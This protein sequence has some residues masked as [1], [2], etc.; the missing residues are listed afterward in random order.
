MFL[1]YFCV[2]KRKLVILFVA[3]LSAVAARAQYDA[4]FSHYWSLQPFY[5]PASVGK[6]SKINIA[7][8]YAMN[9]VGFTNNPKTMYVGADM[10]FYFMDAYHGVGVGFINDQIGLFKHQNIRVQYSYSTRL[11]G[12]RLRIGAQVGLLTESFDGSKLDLEESNDPAFFTSEQTGHAVDLGAGVY[13]SYKDWYA[14]IGAQHLNSPVVEFGEKNEIDLEGTYYFN[15]GGNIKLRNPF[16]SLQ[17][18]VFIQT[19]FVEHKE[20]I[21]LRGTYNNEEKKFEAGLSYS[22]GTSFTV[23]LGGNLHGISLGY[24][25]EIYT[26]ALN[27]GNGSHEL[28]LGYQIDMNLYKKGRNKHKSVRLL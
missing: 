25:Y 8:A 1:R 14:G 17:P 24:S 27:I 7:A 9:L 19:D 3:L 11:F 28:T 12:G 15:A 21:T 5:N 16:L 18:S 26:S 10:P 4:T 22:P 2:F 13:Y 23:L 6:D 20:Q